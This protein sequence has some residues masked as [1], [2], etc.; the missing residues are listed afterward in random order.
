M[1]EAMVSNVEGRG[2]ARSDAI[3]HG[4]GRL[5]RRR[6]TSNFFIWDDK[7]GTEKKYG[8]CFRMERTV[9]RDS[10]DELC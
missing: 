2:L 3:D 5:E 4:R 9:K 7:F 1:K 10:G 8:S 6:K